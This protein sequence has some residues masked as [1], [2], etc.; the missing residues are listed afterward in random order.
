ML[1]TQMNNMINNNNAINAIY[2]FVNNLNNLINRDNIVRYIK[3]EL[4]WHILM[5]PNNNNGA[6]LV[7]EVQNIYN[8]LQAVQNII[9]NNAELAIIS[10][11][12]NNLKM[13][14]YQQ[15]KNIRDMNW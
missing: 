9:M 5:F 11:V 10:N 2:E 3:A 15:L 13:L 12:I 14:N 6:I 8:E 1:N 4:D 7:A